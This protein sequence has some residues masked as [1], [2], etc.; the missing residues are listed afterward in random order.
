MLQG[1]RE[2]G[3]DLRIIGT[4][5]RAGV[6]RAPGISHVFQVPQP[7]HETYI[8]TI[9]AIIGKQGVD[10]VVPQTT[11]EVEHLAKLRGAVEAPVLA[12]NYE[13]VRNANDKGQVS[14]LF[15]AHGWG[16][17]EFRLT[18]SE[19]DLLSAMYTLGYPGQPVVVKVPRL[20]G[21]RGVR[22]IADQ[23]MSFADFVSLKPDGMRMSLSDL[24]KVLSS[25][26]E[27]PSLLVTEYI[28]GTE[29]SVDGFIGSDRRT[30]VVRRRDEIRSGITF[31]ATI[32][33]DEGLERISLDAASSLGLTGLF[34]FQ[35]IADTSGPKVLEC[36]PRIQGSMVGSVLSG[37][38]LIWFAVS[39][40]L[41]LEQDIPCPLRVR[42]R[43]LVCDRYWGAILESDGD[44]AYV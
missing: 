17:P 23:G 44:I 43:Q 26:R 41:G 15:A 22:I 18:S 25:A 24:L 27:W 29:F 5:A 19:E 8:E 10:L 14:K 42:G 40:A 13:A 35:Y 1:S 31:R 16:S 4:D 30:A 34:G 6:R 39:A 32:I 9:N 20:S 28:E 37:H 36:N 11:R 33:D 21:G 7:D 2:S 12:A 3:L 38:N